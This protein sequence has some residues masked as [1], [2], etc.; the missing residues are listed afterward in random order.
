MLRRIV[1][2][3]FAIALTAVC[4]RVTVQKRRRPTESAPGATPQRAEAWPRNSGYKTYV[5]AG[6]RWREGRSLYR[7]PDETAT[8]AWKTRSN[9]AKDPDGDAWGG[10][11]YSP[12]A[13]LLFVPLSYMP[14]PAGEV[15]W[16][17]FLM[18]TSLGGLLWCCRIGLPRPAARR[19][20]ALLLLLVL[21]AYTACLNDGQSSCLIVGC[22]LGVVAAARTNRWTLCA[23][24]ATV[25][26]LLKLYPVSVGLLM[27]VIYPRRFGWRFAFTLAAG[28]ALPFLLRPSTMAA[29]HARWLW[30]LLHDARPSGSIVQW[31]QDIRLLL[32]RLLGLRLS[33]AAYVAVEAAAAALIAAICVA[34]RLANWPQRRLLTRMLSLAA[35]WMTA[36]G[37]ATEPSTYILI[38]PA[39]AWSLWESSLRI[40]RTEPNDSPAVSAGAAGR[41]VLVTAYL[42][43]MATHVLLWF[44]WGRRANSFGLDPAAGL[45]L[46]GYLI[47]RSIKEL[48]PGRQWSHGFNDTV[49]PLFRAP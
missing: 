25:P 15:V 26:A 39:L 44:P 21:P 41:I 2:F 6:R 31:D 30:Q 37:P 38:A 32:A 24:L 18:L 45:L 47:R 4:V 11:R 35:C 28:L 42:L 1:L 10:Y 27:C 13:A 17:V 33:M 14:G 9:P 19:D 48:T 12:T 3:A 5:L 20:W 46:F 43:L 49:G 40:S 29:E 36:L 22:L 8:Q 16:R 23:V 7:S 34:G